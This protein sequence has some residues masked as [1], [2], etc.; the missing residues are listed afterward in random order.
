MARC[1]CTRPRRKTPRSSNL[2]ARN[3]SARKKGCSP[4]GTRDLGD[5]GR[6]SRSPGAPW[7]WSPDATLFVRPRA[8]NFIRWPGSKRLSRLFAMPLPKPAQQAAR[9][10]AMQR[11]IVLPAKLMVASVVLYYL[12]YTHWLAE[13]ATPREVVLETLQRFFILYVVLNSLAAIPLILRR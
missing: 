4:A 12:F 6:W 3:L 10:L 8:M 11:N 2:A 5:S 1:G 7:N 13:V 9:I